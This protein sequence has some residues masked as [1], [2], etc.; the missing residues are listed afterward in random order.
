MK[1]FLPNQKFTLAI[2]FAFLISANIFTNLQIKTVAIAAK[3]DSNLLKNRLVG[4]DIKQMVNDSNYLIFIPRELTAKDDA[5]GR[6][7]PGGKH[8]GNKCPS[9]SLPLTALVPGE[10]AVSNSQG[11]SPVVSVSKSFRTLTAK[12][13]PTFWFYVPYGSDFELD[14]EFVLTT[15]NEN[16]KMSLVS[17]TVYRLENT[18]GIIPIPLSLPEIGK[19]YYW[20]FTIK[21]DK[22]RAANISVNGKIQQVKPS[23]QFTPLETATPEEKAILYARDGLWNDAL[24][25]LIKEVRPRDRQRATLLMTQLLQSVQLDSFSQQPIVECCTPVEEQ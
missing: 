10:E 14:A 22:D 24:S 18:P 15:L 21:C 25:T 8:G 6:R 12:A 17:K 23:P 13:D 2:T 20:S 5:P 16:Q 1:L 3:N 7:K 4:S 9:V 11:E 19:D